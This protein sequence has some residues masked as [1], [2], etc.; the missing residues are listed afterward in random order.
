MYVPDHNTIME[1]TLR[2]SASA[3]ST[4]SFFSFSIR[5]ASLFLSVSISRSSAAARSFSSAANRASSSLNP[6]HNK[7][8]LRKDCLHLFGNAAKFQSK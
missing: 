3:F 1:S 7:C 2:V 6:F 5:S 4:S 8:K